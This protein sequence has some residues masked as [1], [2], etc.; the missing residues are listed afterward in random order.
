MS[1]NTGLCK[2]CGISFVVPNKLKD[3]LCNVEFREHMK[4]D[5]FLRLC[6][7]CRAHT[8][9]E[10][11]IGENLQ[12][13]PR[14]WGPPQ[15][16]FEELKS[17]RFDQRTGATVYKSYC[18][19]CG[20]GCDALVFEKDGKVI[21]VEG[22]PSSPI[23]TGTLCCK[24]LA[25][26]EQLYHRDRLLYPMKRIGKRGG[27]HWQRI[28]WDEALETA[29]RRFNEIE[30]KYGPHSIAL[31]TGTKKGTWIEYVLRFANAWGKQIT[32]AG[33][34]Q[35]ALPRWSAG[36]MVLGGYA[37]EC[38]D[39]SRANCI[40]IWGANP[41][42]N[43]PHHVPPLMDGWARG[44]PLIVVDPELRE[45]S[46]KADVW[47]QLRP[48]TDA[49]LGLGFLN[50]II[51][52]QLYDR[53]FVDKW[54]LGF[55]ELRARVQEYD[56]EKIERITWVPKEKIREAAR[57]YATSKPACMMHSVALDQNAD[58]LSSCLATVML[59][60]ITGNLDVPG[61]N[62]F[63]LFEGVRGR[64]DSD[65]S[66]K[67]LVTEKIEKNIL[68]S[69][70]YPLLSSNACMIYP[71][72]HNATLWKAML[73]GNPYPV[74]GM[75]IHG[76][77]L[78]VNQ[79]NCKQV[80][81]ALRSLE[82]T[83]VVEIMMTPTAEL[84][85]VILPATTWIE[86]DDVACYHQASY[87]V[88]RSGQTVLRLGEC[89]TNYAIINDLAQRLGVK[90]MFPPES[91]EPFFDFM[92]EKAGLTW[93]ELKKRGGYHFPREYKK[94]QRD[95]FNTPSGKVELANSRMKNLGLDPLPRYREADE[96]PISTPE[97]AKQY[98]LIIT[99]GGRTAMFRHSEGRNISILR[100]LMPHPLMSINPMTAERLGIRDGDDV[101]V[102]SPRGSMEAK[103]YLTEGIHP[104]VVQLPSHWTGD[105]NVNL[106]MD[107]EHS[108][109]FI[110][111]AQ[112]RCQLCRVKRKK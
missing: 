111:S 8:F 81:Q 20:C 4:S 64:G 92:L 37:A 89:R 68:G 39:F 75:Y 99:T 80:I 43:W 10:R 97:L 67:H 72:A 9:A 51:N 19:I 54:C 32:Y 26:K 40:L 91:D 55:D 65:F 105:K 103:A 29:V 69:T 23:N 49:A 35:C 33:W 77:N 7:K 59:P 57:L 56:L 109:P 83:L 42:N 1:E 3:I 98:P 82:F 86:R 21:K 14:N 46:S 22:D 84:A 112:L 108:A 60:A 61:G 5:D 58:T 88:V 100:D 12:R 52:E 76:T 106:I 45:T 27:G 11:T 41:A 48:G 102:E 94:Y 36:L 15:R 34:A 101:I 78:A 30:K 79:A 47:L 2:K 70:E 74:K 104:K 6:P 17:V 28:S 71:S 24:G 85:D 44:T 87:N 66:L 95:G 50:V 93:K 13:V 18:A 62:L 16:R 110:G 53:E 38:P 63:S 96:S 107:N 73:T 90:N 25:S 31:A